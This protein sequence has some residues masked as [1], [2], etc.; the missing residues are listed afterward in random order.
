MCCF[1][2]PLPPH[3]FSEETTVK[4]AIKS[5]RLFDGSR[6]PIL[7]NAVVVIDINRI[8][9]GGSASQV[10]LPSDITVVDAGDRT[11]MPGLIDAHVHML[12]TGSEFSGQE[13]RTATDSQA[14]LIG[15]RNA[16]LALKSGL[17]TVRDCGDRNYLSLVLRDYINSGEFAGPRLVCSEP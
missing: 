15:A 1:F 12:F 10:A 9:A 3:T 14:L 8:A 17:T 5:Q 7:Q 11:I 2:L 13:S 16:Y 4:W 6:R